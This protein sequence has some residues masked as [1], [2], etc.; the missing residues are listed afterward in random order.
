MR[1]AVLLLTCLAALAAA[2]V[3]LAATKTL[4]ATESDGLGYSKSVIKVK[5]GKVTIKMAN[6]GSNHLEHSIDIKGNGVSAHS[7]VVQPGKTAS[8]TATLKKGK[9]YTFYCGVSGHEQ[10]GMKGKIKVH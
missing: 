2:S 1:R 9:T 5:H 8:V 3:A 6:P 7:A 10:D 4:K